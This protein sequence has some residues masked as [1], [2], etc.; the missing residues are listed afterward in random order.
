M[1]HIIKYLAIP[2]TY[3]YREITGTRLGFFLPL[4]DSVACMN[5]SE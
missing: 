4:F 3:L 1:Y 2:Y 5:H